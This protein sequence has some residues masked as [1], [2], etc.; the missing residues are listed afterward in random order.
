MSLNYNKQK[1]TFVIL[2]FLRNKQTLTIIVLDESY[3]V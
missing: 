1:K 3:V 2:M